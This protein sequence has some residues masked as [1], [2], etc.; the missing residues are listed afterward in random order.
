MADRGIWRFRTP[1]PSPVMSPAK[2]GPCSRAQGWQARVSE[3][4]V[5]M[6]ES[7]TKHRRYERVELVLG[8]G[9]M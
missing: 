8:G 7:R 6:R 4:T 9:A 3:H 2:A 1:W 5:K